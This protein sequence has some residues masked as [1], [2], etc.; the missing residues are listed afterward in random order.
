MEDQKIKNHWLYPEYAVMRI[1]EKKLLCDEEEIREEYLEN[2]GVNET[3]TF[4]ETCKI[5]AN[6]RKK[7]DQVER[8][9]REDM[10]IDH[11][12]VEP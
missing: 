11:K 9:L 2:M 12:G 1:R 8:K 5:F 3:D 10:G 7:L 4:N 6:A